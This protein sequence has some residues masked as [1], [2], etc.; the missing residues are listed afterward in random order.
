MNMFYMNLFAV[1]YQYKVSMINIFKHL[2]YVSSHPLLVKEKLAQW[3][4]VLPLM[5]ETAF[6][7]P[8]NAYELLIF[9]GLCMM[10][11]MIWHF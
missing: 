2:P 11:K 8:I 5:L 6:S 4:Q 1:K 9:Y 3:I 7:Y 10:Q